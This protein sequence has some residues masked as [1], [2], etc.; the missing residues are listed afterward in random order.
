MTSWDVILA[1][2]IPGVFGTQIK[3]QEKMRSPTKCSCW[4]HPLK[5]NSWISCKGRIFQTSTFRSVRA[6]FGVSGIVR[7]HSL[8]HGTKSTTHRNR[9][10][11]RHLQ[12]SVQVPLNWCSHS[13]S[14]S[15]FGFGLLH[16]WWMIRNRSASRFGK[17]YNLDLTHLPTFTI[18]INQMQV[19][20]PYMNNGM[21]MI[22][23]DGFF[24]RVL[25]ISAG[26]LW[27]WC[28]KVPTRIVSPL[29]ITIFLWLKFKH[30]HSVNI[31]LDFQK[32]KSETKNK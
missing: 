31:I 14:D 29:C 8:D 30:D 12:T 3:L 27:R 26:N 19:N 4:N 11:Q 32:E 6:F 16:S 10:N 18:N 9:F 25:C 28:L 23:F 20:V 7:K 5:T 15:V 17:N 22:G 2:G 13:G 1:A 24:D 21:G